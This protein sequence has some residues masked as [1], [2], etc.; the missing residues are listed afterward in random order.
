MSARTN[1]PG[2]RGGAG[3]AG[4][5]ACRAPR[6]RRGRSRARGAPTPRAPERRAPA[7]R[8]VI[9][10]S[11]RA[12]SRPRPRPGRSMSVRSVKGGKGGGSACAGDRTAVVAHAR[13]DCDLGATVP[14]PS[15]RPIATRSIPRGASTRPVGSRARRSF[16][17]SARDDARGGSRTTRRR[18]HARARTRNR[19]LK[20]RDGHLGKFGDDRRDLDRQRVQAPLEPV[21]PH[22]LGEKV[23][24]STVAF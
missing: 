1:S 15:A 24:H 11:D 16:G 22:D 21:V 4:R 17:P 19:V 23:V 8:E 7:T 3:G 6:P 12:R 14:P 20:H 9:D 2:A 5:R 18:A 10:R 13:N